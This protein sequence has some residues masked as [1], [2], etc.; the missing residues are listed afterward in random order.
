MRNYLNAF[1]AL[2]C[3]I[4]KM[5][6]ARL[7]LLAHWNS[8]SVPFQQNLAFGGK[9]KGSEANICKGSVLF[10]I[11]FRHWNWNK[12]L[13]HVWSNVWTNVLS[14][15]ACYCKMCFNSNL[16]LHVLYLTGPYRTEREKK[17]D[18][19]AHWFNMVI[20]QFFE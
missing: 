17:L 8:L 16:T 15:R 11:F 1:K 13:P 7:S 14:W 2:F 19:I 4:V 18:C 6:F 5:N 9:A 3:K 20:R 10:N 12:F